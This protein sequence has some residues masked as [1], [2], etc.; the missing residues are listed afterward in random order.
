VYFR[1]FTSRVAKSLGVKGYVRNVANSGDV[2]IQ[3]EGDR[4]KLEEMLLA[5]EKGPPEAR[6]ENIDVKWSDYTG[7]FPGFDVRY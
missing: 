2:E 7:E 6:V 5:V 1:A 3:A 4:A